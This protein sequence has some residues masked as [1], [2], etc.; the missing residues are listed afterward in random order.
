MGRLS[1]NNELLSNS[2]KKE[3]RL[4]HVFPTDGRGKSLSIMVMDLREK[5][6]RRLFG[7]H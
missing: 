5:Y 3:T 1:E 6:A 7:G 4:G 2:C